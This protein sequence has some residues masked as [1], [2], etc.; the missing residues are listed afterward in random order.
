[1]LETLKKTIY[2]GIGATVISAEKLNGVLNDLVEK[3]K[4]SSK[5]A[6]DLASK[7]A[8]E[9]RREFEESS[10]RVGL[11]VDEWLRKANFAREKDLQD[12]KARV[13]KLEAA[14]AQAPKMQSQ[15]QQQQ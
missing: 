13:E 5:D 15:Q 6:Q 2:A 9:G 4:L 3:G 8:D 7:I 11:L 14:L 10:E 1:M 12:L